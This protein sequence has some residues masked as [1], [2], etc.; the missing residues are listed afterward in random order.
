[1]YQIFQFL[2]NKEEQLNDLV[3]R[4]TA[5]RQLNNA[6]SPFDMQVTKFTPYAEVIVNR[7]MAV[8]QE[9]ELPETKIALLNTLSSL[10]IRMEHHVGTLLLTTR[11]KDISGIIRE[12]SITSLCSI[13]MKL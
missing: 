7:L 1:M 6:L 8:V 11:R 9:V 2:L 4:V 13:L 3:V 5:G 10:V 12:T